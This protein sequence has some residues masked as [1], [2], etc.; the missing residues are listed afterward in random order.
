M[1]V[2]DGIGTDFD[3]VEFNKGIVKEFRDNDGVCGGRFEGN[4]M[5]LLTTTG[6]KSGRRLTSPLTYTSDSD[7][8][9]V[10]ASKAGADSH[11]AWYHNLVAN[12]DVTIE[13]GTDT[14]A[15]IAESAPEPERTR[16]Y[17]AQTAAMPRFGEYQE[18]TDRVIP[19]VVIRRK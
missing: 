13:I 12:P 1:A 17:D 7:N 2:N 16:L 18:K 14:Y 3:W 9:V 19:V 6:A 8:L 5:I 11:P 10:I 15:A 4:P